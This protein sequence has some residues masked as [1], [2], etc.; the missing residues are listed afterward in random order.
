[1]Q[2]VVHG[3]AGGAPE[4]PARRRAVLDEAASRG[5]RV[6]TPLDAVETAVRHLESDPRFNAGVGGAVQ[7]DGAV[8]T[9]AGAMTDA[10]EVGAVAGL[11]GVEHPITVARAV[12]AETPHVLLAGE[13]ARRFAADVGVETDR[14]LYTTAT[15]ARW[16][17]ADP[18]SPSATPRDHLAWVE[19][20]FGASSSEP[21]DGAASPPPSGPD[22]PVDAGGRP[23]GADHDTVGA[24]AREGDS[25]AAAT[26]TGGRWCALAGRVGD[27]P[28]VGSG[29]YCAPA[30]GA[31]ATGAGEDIARVTLARRA[32]AHLEAGRDAQTAAD[33]AL[34][35]F[36]SVAGS[37]A[38]LV[39][40]GSAD[41]G[42]GAAYDT[43]AM[44]TARARR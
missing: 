7:S 22:A 24:V 39:V 10:R 21:S 5:A 26:S 34:A 9:D 25:F 16:D 14:D 37:A 3:G 6:E 40:L 15:R 23:D 8:R 30:G 18:P 11:A 43:E 1:V 31:S 38:G 2:L 28:Q 13:P 29:F 27:V 17:E 19:E 35:E 32:V 42:V 12:L 20:R 41:A 33:A 36:E 4:T 44:Q